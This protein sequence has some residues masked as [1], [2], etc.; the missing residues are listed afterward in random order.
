M[1]VDVLP[2]SEA[3]ERNKDP[4]LQIL[5]AA[6]HGSARVLEVGSGTG[7]HAV[8]F[9]KHLPELLWQPADRGEYLS[10]IHI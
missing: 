10:L 4:I 3:C 6:L 9:C 7:Q 8:Y 1:S 2:L 5:K